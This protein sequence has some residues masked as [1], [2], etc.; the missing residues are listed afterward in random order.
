MRLKKS[1]VPITE[2]FE[3]VEKEIRLKFKKANTKLPLI[4]EDSDVKKITREMEAIRSLDSN[5]INLR[6]KKT[7]YTKILQRNII[8][9]F[10]L[11]TIVP[12]FVNRP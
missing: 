8:K 7:I 10:F 2:H 6:R 5:K 12:I 4:A 9:L 11:D 3:T 1:N